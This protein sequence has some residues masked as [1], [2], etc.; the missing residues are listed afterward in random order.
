[1]QWKSMC[2]KLVVA[3]LVVSMLLNGLAGTPQLKADPI[4]VLGNYITRSGDKLMDGTSEFR[5]IGANVPTLT[6]VED[7]YWQVPTEWE[8]RDAFKALQQMGATATR[9]YV[10]SV[11]KATDYPGMIRHVQGPGQFNEDAFV[12]LDRALALANEYGI[13]LIIPFVDQ[14]DWWGGIAEYAAFRGKGKD[15]FWTNSQIKDDFKATINYVLNRTNTITNVKYKD[16]KA[17]LAWETGNELTPP[18]AAWTTEMGTYIKSIDAN[19]LLIDGKYGIDSS[20]LDVGS[21]IDIVSNHYYPNHYSNFADQVN[22]DKN[23]ARGKK[24]FYVGEFGFIPKTQLAPFLNNVI[25]SGTSGALIWSLRYHSEDGGFFRHTEGTYGGTFYEAYKWPGFPA[26]ESS[27][28]ESSVLNL[29]RDKAYEIRGI[30]KPA[31]PVPEAPVILPIDT[32]SRIG[33]QGSTGAT[34]YTVERS[35]Y[36]AGPWDIIGAQVF[37]AATSDL[38]DDTTSVTGATYFYRTK[39][40]NT[41]GESTYSPVVGPVIAKHAIQDDLIDYSKMYQFSTDLKFVTDDVDPALFAGDHNR[42]KLQPDAVDQFV[43]YA[44]PSTPSQSPAVYG[45]SLKV[46]AFRATVHP[47]SEFK[48]WTSVDGTNYTELPVL[49]TETSGGSWN[50]VQYESNS[51][52]AHAKYYKVTFPEGD[53][54]SQLGGVEIEY[55][56]TSGEGLIYKEPITNLA[57]TNGVLTDEMNNLLKMAEHSP[58]LGFESSSAADYFGNDAKRLVRTANTAES[59]VYHSAGDMN[60]FVMTSYARQNANEYR[61]P[62]FTFQTSPD[63]EHYTDVNNVVVDEVPGAGYWSRMVYTAYMLPSGTKYVKVIFPVIP[64]PAFANNFWTPQVGRMQIGVG[65]ETLEPPVHEK[66]AVIENFEGYT[67]SDSTLRSAYTVNSSGSQL[68]LA[69]D[70][71]HKTEGNYSLKLTSSLEKGWG[72]MEKA[73]TNTD[74]S[75]HSGISFWVLP[76]ATDTGIS[77]QFNEGMATNG[78]VWKKDIRVSG[79]E[80]QLIT[81]PFNQFYVADWWKNSHVGQGNNRV[82]LSSITTFSLNI[83]G[84]NAERILYFDD[85]RLYKSPVVDTFEGYNGDNAKL[86][87]QYSRNT[88]GDMMTVALDSEHKQSGDYGVKLDY[89]LTDKGYAGVTKSIG[90]ADWSAYNGLQL[91]VE[92]GEAG[93]GVTY[94]I[95]EASGEYWE[96]KMFLSDTSAHAVGIPFG[97]FH[98]PSWSNVNGL[99]DLNA[100]DEFS[101]YVDKGSGGNGAGFLYLDD[102]AAVSLKE[103]D[104]FDFYASNGGL[105]ADYKPDSWGDTIT[106]TLENNTKQAGNHAM[107]LSYSLSDDKGYAGVIRTLGKLNLSQGGNAI[108]F[109]MKSAVAGHGLTFQLK[110]NDGDIWE[111]QMLISSTDEQVVQI[112]F[113]GFARNQTWSTGDKKLNRAEITSYGIFVNKGT[114]QAGANTIYIDSI[115]IDSVPTIEDFDYYGGGELVAGGAYTTNV[116]GGPVTLTPDA[117]HKEAGAFGGK[118]AYELTASANFAGVNKKL[119]NLDWSSYEGIRFWLKKDASNRKLTI[120]FL[121]EDG[122]AWESYITLNDDKSGVVK[123]KFDKDF[124]RA[125]WSTGGNDTIDL[126]AV[127][128]FSMYINQAEG[129][130]GAGTL[131]FDTIKVYKTGEE[132][133]IPVTPEPDPE[134]NADQSYTVGSISAPSVVEESSQIKLTDQALK[135]QTVKDSQGKD[136]HQAIINAEDMRKALALL[137]KNQTNLPIVLTYNSSN[138]DEIVIPTSVLSEALAANPASLATAVITLRSEVGSYEIPLSLMLNPAIQKAIGAGAQD[139]ALHIAISSVTAEQAEL[140]RKAAGAQGAALIGNPVSFRLVVSSGGK[141]TE[142][143]NFGSQFITRSIVT[144]GKQDLSTATVV[145]FDE[146]TG[147]M[148]FVPTSFKVHGNEGEAVISRNGNSVYAILTHQAS[149]IDVPAKHWAKSAIDT[150]ASKFLLNG[151]TDITFAPDRDIT[152]AE[153][154]TMLVKALGI[155][156]VSNATPIFTDVATQDWFA[157]AIQAASELALVD[158][159]EDRSFQPNATITREQMAVMLGRALTLTKLTQLVKPAAALSFTDADMVSTWAES[160]LRVATAVGLINGNADGSFRPQA[161]ATRAEA[162]MVFYNLLQKLGYVQ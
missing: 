88:S 127:K 4:S 82:D 5:F 83:D 160:S 15:E 157:A 90:G 134:P 11:T 120:Q 51:L 128:E 7:G 108:S 33:W 158:G 67:G 18:S 13:R 136:M 19:H 27:F 64:N 60:Y 36:A 155:V 45:L 31:L 40:R 140:V 130:I 133:D 135:L 38:F 129:A 147:A 2:A 73:L 62:N 148:T 95:K 115:A 98:R 138:I 91:W 146:T 159:F 70:R 153:F 57:I 86:Q 103:I 1:M 106:A 50:Q 142:I 141:Q 137:A 107:K 144:D 65:S 28:E 143:D 16:D 150:L 151:M 3:M 10:L 154:T 149:F 20:S 139:A 102:I 119:D 66:S 162:A 131:Y 14:Y 125:P 121:E 156:P 8:Q 26:G 105:Q 69:L 93:R 94:Q 37:D 54:Q 56:H 47:A 116:W 123:L 52:P 111:A 124:T 72:G 99:L 46:T 9:T 55:N 89:V 35:V 152:R 53:G 132:V 74:W 59:F 80:P 96:A 6:M 77:I 117:A 63:G 101:V 61:L 32:I 109:W 22:V 58:N 44:L 25:E 145:V 78:E 92:A 85:F 114:G 24:P 79:N 118:Y 21:P 122:S 75:G 100:I 34:S 43:A 39:A 87:A 42:V 76:A 81:L 23:M 104:S 29:L 161:M 48:V 17:I 12:A 84:S 112:P 126:Q 49:K 110:E 30:S 113:S 68:L 71:D 97:A 41:V